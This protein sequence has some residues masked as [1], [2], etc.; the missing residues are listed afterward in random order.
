MHVKIVQSQD[1]R[2]L[3]KMIESNRYEH[4]TSII[5]HFCPFTSPHPSPPSP[6]VTRIVSSLWVAS[7]CKRAQQTPSKATIHGIQISKLPHLWTFRLFCPKIGGYVD[8]HGFH[9][10]PMVSM[11]FPC[12]FPMIFWGKTSP[13]FG[14]LCFWFPATM[15]ALLRHGHQNP[16]QNGWMN[17]MQRFNDFAS[18]LRLFGLQA[19]KYVELASKYGSWEL[20]S[21]SLQRCFSGWCINKISLKLHVSNRFNWNTCCFLWTLKHSSAENVCR[22]L[23]CNLKK[24]RG[25][26]G[27]PPATCQ[28]P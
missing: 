14:W 9:L 18:R 5:L 27:V 21:W 12:D 4:L 26:L 1:T 23:D 20:Q 7:C 15:W 6:P 17:W 19:F 22:K 16:P 11:S 13:C 3:F 28:W 8:I 24:T 25:W 10:I 2:K